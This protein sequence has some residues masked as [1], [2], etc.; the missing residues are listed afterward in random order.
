MRLTRC[1]IPAP[2]SAGAVVMLPEAAATHV[3][4]VLRL[5]TGAALTLFDGRGGEYA[6]RLLEIG[7][8]GATARVGEHRAVER[9]ATLR[10][11]LLQCL[12]RA[13][14]M[15]WIV[16]KTTELGV[17]A[18][19]PVSGLHSVVQLAA[20]ARERR[21]AHWRAVAVS[22]CEQCGRNHVPD[23][24]PLRELDAACAEADPA[25]LRLLLSP[26][27][28]VSL[29]AALA[30]VTSPGAA[31]AAATAA[32]ASSAGTT[33]ALS[34]TLL[35]GPEGGFAAQELD[36]ARQHGFSPCRLG[37]RILRAETAPVAALAAIQA[38]LGDIR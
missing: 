33:A 14:R 10:V 12:A 27:A 6:A 9:E 23:I 25:S 30:P 26:E 32:A 2:L 5:P 34:V 18:I 13:E 7:R 28:T 29:P 4:R 21:L 35:V 38:V 36:A 3:T 31:A 8:H 11:T 20:G 1:F 15:D 22:A 24:Q 16:Q 37:P 19:V 17:A